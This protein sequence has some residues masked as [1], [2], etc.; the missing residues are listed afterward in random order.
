M[1]H[2]VIKHTDRKKQ[3]QQ[4]IENL[5]NIYAAIGK[6]AKEQAAAPPPNQ[7]K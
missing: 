7:K 6:A 2:R 1:G 5:L 3:K 4:Q